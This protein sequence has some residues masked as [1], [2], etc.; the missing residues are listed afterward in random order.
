VQAPAHNAHESVTFLRAVFGA[1]FPDGAAVLLFGINGGGRNV[2]HLIR[3]PEEALPIV[4]AANEEGSDLYV[5]VA[6]QAANVRHIG[7]KRNT[8]ADGIGIPGLW[9]DI[10]VKTGSAT[11]SEHARQIAHLIAPPTML[12]CTGGGT[13][14]LHAWWTFDEPWMFVDASERE[15]AGRLSRGWQQ[16]HRN[17]AKVHLDSTHD[18]ARVLRLPGTLNQKVSPAGTVAIIEAAEPISRALAEQHTAAQGVVQPMRRKV[19]DVRAGLVFDVRRSPDPDRWASIG[20]ND[21]GELSEIFSGRRK[22]PGRAADQSASG[23][24]FYLASSVHRA[25][26]P[27]QDVLDLMVWHRRTSGNAKGKLSREDYFASTLDRVLAGEAAPLDDLAARE[28]AV[29]AEVDEQLKEAREATLDLKS[30]DSFTLGAPEVLRRFNAIIA[31]GRD[32]APVVVRVEQFSET[33][34]ATVYQLHLADS[35]VLSIPARDMLEPRKFRVHLMTK[36]RHVMIRLPK[37]EDWAAV[38]Q[39]LLGVVAVHAAAESTPEGALLQAA[40]S[41]V[42][43]YGVADQLEDDP[44]Q[45]GRPFRHEDAVWITGSM[46]KEALKGEFGQVQ[47]AATQLH[48]LFGSPRAFNYYVTEGR[49]KRRTQRRYYGIPEAKL[50]DESP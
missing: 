26:W 25:G 8:A 6:F 7:S 43:R 14:G 31:C 36:T 42:D 40:R 46:L 13:G 39:V 33:T 4:Q 9:L 49:S 3:Q 2:S 21:G 19:S 20:M 35:E 15:H 47:N 41:I 27:A 29:D 32:G 45:G 34:E 38:V 30:A 23:R 1:E 11:D 28:V 44:L 18:L 24:E 48:V 12:V 17:L 5:A 10:D 22:V 16:A 50:I 37:L